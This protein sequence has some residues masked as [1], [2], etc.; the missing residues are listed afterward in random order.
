MKCEQVEAMIAD[1]LQ[2]S[3]PQ[4]ALLHFQAHTAHCVA[5]RQSLE[6]QQE[7]WD[8][9]GHW[10]VEEPSRRL[11][12]HFYNMLTSYQAGQAEAGGVDLP[13]RQ[14]LRLEGRLRRLLPTRPGWQL[15]FVAAV[16]A[17]GLWVGT[18]PAGREVDALKVVKRDYE[19]LTQRASLSLMQHQSPSERLSGVR[20]S[21]RLSD[22]DPRV[23]D[24]LL[25]VLN[26]DG[27]VNVRLSAVQALYRFREDAS[28]RSGLVQALG[29]AD[30]P[31]I[32][33]ALIDCLVAMGE[34]RAAP[35]IEDLLHSDNLNPIVRAKAQEGLRHM[36]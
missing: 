18:I 9:L 33:A 17:L 31:M 30:S 19:D 20:W 13:P 7:M 12:D 6:S 10:Q 32:Q 15:L 23:R 2:G 21:S 36:Q 22:P 27:N 14:V 8:Q 5:C 1:F 24:A 29:Q 35:G 26:Y 25:H 16:F 4:G 34:K 11:H 28:V 3:L